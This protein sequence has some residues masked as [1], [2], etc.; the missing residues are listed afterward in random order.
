M[1]RTMFG[2]RL[3]SL[4]KARNLTQEHMA[5]QLG[6]T[7]SSYTCYEIGTS[8][9]GVMTLCMIADIFEVSLDYLMGRTND[10]KLHNMNEFIPSAEEMQLT[11]SYRLLNERQRR[12]VRELLKSF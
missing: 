6:L 9:P 4:R 11:E 8:M 5:K 1:G 3:M 12:A 7:R 2:M 10:Q